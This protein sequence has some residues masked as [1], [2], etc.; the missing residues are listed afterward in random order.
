MLS[1]GRAG[2]EYLAES[3][4]PGRGALTLESEICRVQLVLPNLTEHVPA[5]V[6]VDAS[7]TTVELEGSLHVVLPIVT[8]GPSGTTFPSP[9]K[10]RFPLGD[11]QDAAE[12][13]QNEGNDGIGRMDSYKEYLSRTFKVK[14]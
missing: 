13:A 5:D 9:L 12:H 14:L 8:C 3:F 7:A 2:R 11:D 10:L 4:E 6:F 1:S